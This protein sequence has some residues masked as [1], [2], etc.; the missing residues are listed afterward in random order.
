MFKERAINMQWGIHSLF[1]KCYLEKWIITYGMK[2]DPHLTIL[3]NFNL[4][5][6]KNLNVRPETFKLLGVG[7]GDRRNAPWHCPWQYFFGLGHQKHMQQI[8]NK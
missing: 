5:W 7:G 8:K 6:M 4:K 2:L 1:N 3:T